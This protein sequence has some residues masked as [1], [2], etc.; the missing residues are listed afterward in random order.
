MPTIQTIVTFPTIEVDNHENDAFRL[1]LGNFIKE[2]SPLLYEHFD[3]KDA[4]F[5][6]PLV[7]YK[8]IDKTPV[9]LAY[10][11][12][13][14]WL[15]KLLKEKKKIYF[16]ER[17][18]PISEENIKQA[19]LSVNPTGNMNQYEFKTL[20]LA[21]NSKNYSIY[22]K[23]SDEDRKSFLD[24]NLQNNIISC[25]KGLNYYATERI[26]AKTQLVES[27]TTYNGKAMLGFKGS[28]ETNAILP[29][30]IGVGRLVAH[31]FGA[32]CKR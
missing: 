9:L 15:D 17:V 31:G 13:A 6:Y 19:K 3:D 18:H 10:N 28:F 2:Q 11:E 30:F 16:E 22:K 32:L 8:V 20:W 24:K 14:E 29:E 21:L 26:V 27:R 1:C 4:S 23:L 25:L 5:Y 12:A 7:Q